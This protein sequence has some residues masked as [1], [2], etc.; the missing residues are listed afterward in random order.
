MEKLE[1]TLE[2]QKT[3]TEKKKNLNLENPS[4]EGLVKIEETNYKSGTSI[5]YWM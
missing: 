2:A 4:Y 3:S 1:K 5:K